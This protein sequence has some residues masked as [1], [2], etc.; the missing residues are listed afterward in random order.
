MNLLQLLQIQPCSSWVQTYSRTQMGRRITWETL[1]H[2][3][4]LLM[5]SV[6]SWGLGS[7]GS[8][9]IPVRGYEFERFSLDNF[10]LWFLQLVKR[11]KKSESG[12][13]SF[14]LL[15]ALYATRDSLEVCLYDSL[16]KSGLSKYAHLVA[17][18]LPDMS[19]TSHGPLVG[20]HNSS[21]HDQEGLSQFQAEILG[22]C[23]RDSQGSLQWNVVL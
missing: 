7:A 10:A 23:L 16:W 21:S 2:V 19:P 20:G 18:V 14:F 8:Y 9:G 5:V 12:S 17:S 15:I 13:V 4:G 1:G 6:F 3:I 22:Y 11:P